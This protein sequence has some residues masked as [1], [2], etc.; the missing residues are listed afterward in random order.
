MAGVMNDLHAFRFNFVAD[1]GAHDFVCTRGWLVCDQ[2]VGWNA[3]AGTSLRIRRS[4]AA[5]PTVFADVGPLLNAAT[6]DQNE[7]CESMVSA[8]INFAAG[9]TM[10]V[11]AV[12]NCS[13]DLIV[14]VE[15][16]TW[17]LG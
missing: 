12:G 13:A 5:V 14:E 6:V 1:T 10:R 7:Y 16:T 3:T 2:I 17:I 15:P 11:L 8:Q 4:T 9:D